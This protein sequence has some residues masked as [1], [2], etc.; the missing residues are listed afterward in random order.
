ML[1]WRCPP[2]VALSGNLFEFPVRSPLAMV[3]GSLEVISDL[4]SSLD[5]FM[6][7]RA[8]C[9]GKTGLVREVVL[10]PLEL[11]AACESR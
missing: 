5:L 6:F 9:A 2:V 11:L 1:G 3:I 4:S 10:D 7:P 8:A